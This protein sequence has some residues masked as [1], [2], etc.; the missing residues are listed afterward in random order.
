MPTVNGVLRTA[1]VSFTLDDTARPKG[2]EQSVSLSLTS[3]VFA[4][5]PVVVTSG[6][7]LGAGQ[8]WQPGEPASCSL[9]V[10]T[11][12]ARDLADELV[13]HL[14]LGGP[15]DWASLTTTLWVDLELTFLEPGTTHSVPWAPPRVLV[16]TASGPSQRFPLPA[17]S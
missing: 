7:R 4:R 16:A 13:L 14:K 9:D 12:P 3:T 8:D 1:R 6:E 5:I 10:I 11:F 15:Q 17:L 2:I